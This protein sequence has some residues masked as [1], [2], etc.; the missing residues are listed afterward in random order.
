MFEVSEGLGW[1]W[2]WAG[3]ALLITLSGCATDLPVIVDSSD[4]TGSLA[5]GR[6]ATVIT[7]ETKRIYEP[8]LRSFELVN[9]QTHERFRVDVQSDDQ[10]FTLSLPP[11]EYELN[12]VQI[13]EGPFMSMAQLSASF[14][15]QQGT[16]TYLGTW[17]FGVD[18]PRYGRMV[19][20]SMIV[21]EQYRD[22]AEEVIRQTYPANDAQSVV[23]VLPDPTESEARL[24]EVMPYPRVPRYFQR[25]QW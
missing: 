1:P 21:D 3:V 6:V 9:R 20:L 8:F 12:R 2:T 22:Q 17:R 4:E 24:Y 19:V 16:I 13:N 23:T 18:S 25:H 5:V 11:G 7:G 14:A 15:L 10:Q